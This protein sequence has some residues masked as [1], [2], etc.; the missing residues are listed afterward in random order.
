[1]ADSKKENEP[2]TAAQ[3]K[4]ASTR[5]NAVEAFGKNVQRLASMASPTNG[6]GMDQA[7]SATRQA[8]VDHLMGQDPTGGAVFLTC[9][10]LRKLQA[11][12]SLTANI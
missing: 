11:V 3:E 6:P 4:I 10:L 9:G 5:I 1:M 8:V 7:L 12:A 2:L